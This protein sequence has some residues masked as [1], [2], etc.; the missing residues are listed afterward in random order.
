M[1]H[2]PQGQPHLAPPGGASTFQAGVSGPEHDRNISRRCA[3]VLKFQ[4]HNMTKQCGCALVLKF[5]DH[6]M[7]KQCGRAMVL[8]VLLSCYTGLP[9]GSARI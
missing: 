2:K 1:P 3:E 9:H 6:N 4:D 7:T 5:Q 8:V